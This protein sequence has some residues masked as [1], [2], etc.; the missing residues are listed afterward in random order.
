MVSGKVRRAVIE[1]AKRRADLS[2][3][4][5]P[6]EH[7]LGRVTR[8]DEFGKRLIRRKG[9]VPPDVGLGF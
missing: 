3:D 5:E 6:V 2:S 7:A 9:T 8:K 4:T 1:E